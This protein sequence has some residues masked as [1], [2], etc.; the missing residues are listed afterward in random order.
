MRTKGF[1]YCLTINRPN[2]GDYPSDVL[3]RNQV[4]F[5]YL[6]VG[7][8]FAPVT[9]T[10]HYQVAVHFSKEMK[11]KDIKSLFPLA[12]I[13]VMKSSL[14]RNVSY[15]MKSG[16]FRQHGDLT[17]ALDIESARS[18]SLESQAIIRKGKKGKDSTTI[19][20]LPSSCY[21]PFNPGDSSVC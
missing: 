7:E 10:F 18:A 13:E 9:G 17:R 6:I 21:C 16:H 3:I 2:V 12:H 19:P 1:G 14:L 8:E 4:D 5:V 20:S 11:W 15:C